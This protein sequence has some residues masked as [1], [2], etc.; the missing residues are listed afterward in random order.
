MERRS[1]QAT[2]FGDVVSSFSDVDILVLPQQKSRACTHHTR[3]EN[4]PVE[5]HEQ[6]HDHMV[7]RPFHCVS[8][9]KDEVFKNARIE[10]NLVP[11]LDSQVLVQCPKPVVFPCFGEGNYPLHKH[12]IT[13][14]KVNVAIRFPGCFQRN[15]RLQKLD[16]LFLPQFSTVDLVLE[17]YSSPPVDGYH[18]RKD[19]HTG[20]P[21]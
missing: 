13:L 19:T 2:P 20:T 17:E 4:I 5:I 11:D 12:V 9:T 7:Y 14:C 1:L 18:Q 8:N 21:K 16:Y 15:S 3:N 10:V 6:K